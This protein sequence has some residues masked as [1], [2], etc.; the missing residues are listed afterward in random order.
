MSKRIFIVEDFHART[1]RGV[2]QEIFA[3][4]VLITLNRL[5]ANRADIELNSEGT[6]NPQSSGPGPVG[7]KT[8]FKNCI[9]VLE[10]G[11]EELLLFQRRITDVVQRLFRTIVGRYQRVRPN[12]SFIPRS[13]KPETKWQ[14]SKEKRQ[15][16]KAQKAAAAPA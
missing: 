15:A 10:Q 6:S 5:F 13:M 4:F 16:Q 14:P 2:K 1:E 7:R 3:H 12:R 8:N 11:L 9:H